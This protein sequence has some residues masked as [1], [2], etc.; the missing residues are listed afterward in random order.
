MRG[1]K[2]SFVEWLEKALRYSSNYHILIEK[3][4]KETES[5]D[6]ESS[7]SSPSSSSSKDSSENSD[8]SE[9]EKVQ[10]E[11]NPQVPFDIEEVEFVEETTL[12]TLHTVFGIADGYGLSY[13]NFKN[14]CLS[15]GDEKDIFY[16][17]EDDVDDK[18][19]LVI[20]KEF[21]LAF[22]T[23]FISLMESLGFD[24]EIDVDFD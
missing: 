11:E 19:P 22:I 15:A 18:V 13:L 20:L 10:T 16:N 6:S 3:K 9:E 1:G 5:S 2:E 14:L 17:G 23:G 7:S 8:S 21:A 24:R 12:K 4:E